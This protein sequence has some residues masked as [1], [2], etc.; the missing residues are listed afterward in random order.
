MERL[1][2]P[3]S[4]VAFMAWFLSLLLQANDSVSLSATDE[5]E[6]DFEDP[7]SVLVQTV[8]APLV[9]TFSLM[10]TAVQNYSFCSSVAVFH[11]DLRYWVKPRSTTWFS[12]FLLEQYDSSRW[13]SLFRMTKPA[14]FALAEV[15][16]PQVEEKKYQV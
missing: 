15:L 1:T 5:E 3:A 2:S 8:H 9:D 12:R 14:V 16:R 6:V 4:V 10:R 7:M 13:V 11:E